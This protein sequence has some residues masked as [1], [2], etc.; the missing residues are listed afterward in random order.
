M[1]LGHRGDGEDVGWEVLSICSWVRV[2]GITWS[3]L[4]W[5]A[6]LIAVLWSY[7]CIDGTGE[8]CFEGTPKLYLQQTNPCEHMRF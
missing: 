7:Q 4:G 5:N 2:K 8:C 1:A 3:I 6:V